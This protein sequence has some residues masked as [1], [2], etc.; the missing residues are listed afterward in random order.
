V[1]TTLALENIG[2]GIDTARY[3]HRVSF[4]RPDHSPVAAPLT[5]MENRE[6]YQAL[7][8]RLSKLRR[9]HPQAHFHIRID[10]AG[11]YAV[12]IEQFLRGLDLP[13]TLSVGEPK[14]NKDY[15]KAHFPKRTTDDT[16]SQSMARFAV[17][18][19]PTA[20]PS[21]SAAAILLRDVCGR[22]QT[23]VKQ[24]TQAVN[25]LHNLLARAFPELATLTDD[26]A[27]AWVLRL[28]EKYPTA[29]RIAGAHLASLEKIPY[30]SRDKAQAV[31]LAARESVATLRGTV[32]D[33]LIRI[34]VAQVRRSKEAEKD[35]KQLLK[36]AFADLPGSAHRG[37]VTIPGI[38][39][40]TAA[41]L[42]AKI[43]DIN[44]FA[45]ADQLVNYFGIF[46]EENSSGVD[47]Q[48]NPLP[49]GPMHM[50][51]K[52][53]DLVRCYLWNAARVAITH[54]PATKALYHRLKSRGKRGDVALGHCMRKL[55]HL[56]FAVWKTDRPF[57]GEH[58]PW[59]NPDVSKPAMLPSAPAEVGASHDENATAV[60]HTRDLPAGKVVTTAAASVESTSSPVKPVPPTATERP[61]VDFAFL[62]E[63]VKISQVLNHLGLMAR[64]HCRGPQL[65][66]PCPIHGQPTDSSRTFSV[67]VGKNVF[68]CF[69]ATCEAQGNVLDLWAAIHKL[70]LYQA[71]VDL[72][73]TFGLAL[74]REEEPVQR[75][76]SPRKK[77]T[78]TSGCS[79]NAHKST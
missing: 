19:R 49:S 26:I 64:M 58:F 32:A 34:Q 40:T 1:S 69:N 61:P 47:K 54:N 28:L 71:A 70:S 44:R 13:M 3:G 41:I 29:E 56:V 7:E 63:Q 21:P 31:Q 14:R 6:G 16:E 23:Q 11:Q 52:G 72:A 68:R 20:T 57:D 50:S 15:R 78:T 33:D 9:Q 30:L 46:P 39:Q 74:N 8:D 37:I 43:V 51:Q 75:N 12:N 18:E 22:L 35:L 55:L 59:A 67:H 45:T 62:R 10:A 4:L 42:V 36:T 48:G 53:N 27:A 76:P 60:G 17:V 5:V 79:S 2:V 66:G 77:A 25:R 38:G 73:Q 65:R 24:T